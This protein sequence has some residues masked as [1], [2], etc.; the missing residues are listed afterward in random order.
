M[1]STISASDIRNVHI[2]NRRTH[3][4]EIDLCRKHQSE[5]SDSIADKL[6]QLVSTK[7]FQNYFREFL[8]NPNEEV[9]VKIRITDRD[10]VVQELDKDGH[11]FGH[12]QKVKLDQIVNL[13][14]DEIGK[15]EKINQSILKKADQ[16]YQDHLSESDHR[17]RSVSPLHERTE[18][19][20]LRHPHRSRSP[21]EHRDERRRHP[22]EGSRS[23][24]RHRHYR[25][26]R[27][28][29]HERHAFTAPERH[30]DRRRKEERRE[31]HSVPLPF[32]NRSDRSDRRRK[33]RIP[34]LSVESELDLHKSRPS[35]VTARTRTNPPIPSKQLTAIE[36][37]LKKFEEKLGTPSPTIIASQPAERLR[38]IDERLRAMESKINTLSSDSTVTPSTTRELALLKIQKRDLE[39]ELK[40]SQ[41]ENELLKTHLPKPISSLSAENYETL[42]QL[43]QQLGATDVAGSA[44]FSGELKEKFMKLPEALRHAIYHQTYLLVDPLEAQDPWPIGQ[45]LFEGA[46]ESDTATNICR[47][48]AIRHFVLFTL[49]SDF[50][51]ADSKFPPTELIGRFAQIHE[52][53]KN[54]IYT[55]LEYIQPK[56]DDYQG[57]AHAFAGIDR[58]SATNQER[59]IAIHRVILDRIAEYHRH[60]YREGIEVMRKAFQEAHEKL[61]SE[62]LQKSQ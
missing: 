11:K 14:S 6:D 38:A 3:S 7:L 15:A 45:K 53:D 56:G 23:P 33:D 48:H 34:A 8:P 28:D 46:T 4:R 40:A 19:Y 17:D 35:R 41:S 58:L 55:Q 54:A 60:H 62:S 37:R 52:E 42:M 22:R 61:K 30:T 18:R 51:N 1:P 12:S 39:T 32:R 13:T 31:H 36:Q 43:S 2:Y 20:E 16:I 24:E 29:V 27:R 47:S 25:R 57:P 50:A 44:H 26:A 9:H 59:S 10:I 5:L 49:A 21:S